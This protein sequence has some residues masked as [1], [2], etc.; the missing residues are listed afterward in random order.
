[1]WERRRRQAITVVVMVDVSLAVSACGRRSPSMLHPRGPESHKVA[2]IW[3]L[4]FSLAAGVYVVVGGFIVFA[5]LR[6]RRSPEG[7]P[8]KISDSTFIWWGGI[9]VPVLILAVLAAATVSVTRTVRKA[10]PRALRVEVVGKRW[11]WEV[12]YPDSGPTHQ[13]VVTANEIHIPVGRPVEIGVDSD[14]VLHSF[15][16]P[17]LAGKL[18]MVPG[19]HNILRLRADRPGTYRG[20]CAEFCGLE[21]GR[22]AFEI[23]ADQPQ[24]F[25]RWMARYQRTPS[26]PETEA[27]A[28]GELVFTREACAGC[29]TVKGTQA[30]GTLGP[31][32]TNF[33]SRSW[34]GSVTVR[35]DTAHLSGWIANAQSIKPGALMPPIALEPGELDDL[36]LYM[37][38]L[39]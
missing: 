32:L 13:D 31:D 20:Q 16:V 19:Q 27:T 12:R 6:G 36:V 28:R 21:H 35:N 23:V 30:A 24:D 37:E 14:N 3:W 38:S 2:A 11:W 9:I 4:M 25:D 22:M 15:W 34:I 18:D 7:R 10:D 17:E 5:T 26:P 8:S 1:V 39:K 29:H 33:G